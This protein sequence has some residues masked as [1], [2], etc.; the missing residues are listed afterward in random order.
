MEIQDFPVGFRELLRAKEVWVSIPA[1]IWQ[2]FP[3][4][5]SFSEKVD[6]EIQVKILDMMIMKFNW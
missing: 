6:F 4:F 1:C 3:F 2:V 5:C